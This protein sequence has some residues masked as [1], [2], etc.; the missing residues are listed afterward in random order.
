[1][2]NCSEVIEIISQYIDNELDEKERRDFEEHIKSCDSCRTELDEI[3]HVVELCRDIDEVELP[4][5]FREELHR[6]LVDARDKGSFN[7]KVL[8]VRSKYIK[9]FSSI[10]AGLLLIFFVRGMYNNG[11]FSPVRFSGA[12][13][14]ESAAEA[15]R[16]MKEESA[17]SAS[18]KA[19]AGESQAELKMAAQDQEA[20]LDS[21]PEQGILARAES[22][23][24]RGILKEQPAKPPIVKIVEVT[25][26]IES[27]GKSDELVGKIKAFVLENG[28]ETADDG[29][30]NVPK[31]ICYAGEQEGAVAVLSYKVGNVQYDQFINSMVSGLGYDVVVGE[32]KSED[33]SGEIVKLNE[34]LADLDNKIY[35]AENEGNTS[36]DEL[37]RMKNDKE[38]T[39]EQIQSL[40]FETDYT[41]ITIVVREK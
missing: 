37:K 6:K 39:M 34:K 5:D 35:S 23:E 11:Y 40:E 21:A 36:E 8:E 20:S 1:M 30:S 31:S 13:K 14:S 24:D 29:S 16:A 41:F 28:A 19:A 18:M 38:K 12:T 3:R 15:P 4:E 22:V 27:T 9:I 2:K 26:N 7:G 33:L 32:M 10:A 25:V 17:E